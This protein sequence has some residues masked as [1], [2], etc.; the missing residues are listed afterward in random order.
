MSPTIAYLPSLLLRY[1]VRHT[2]SSPPLAG[3][4]TMV[5]V[6]RVTRVLLLRR[7]LQRRHPYIPSLSPPCPAPSWPDL[8]FSRS[9]PFSLA[10][11][12]APHFRALAREGSL[13]LFFISFLSLFSLFPSLP[14]S[15]PSCLSVAL[16][17]FS[18]Y[19]WE[20]EHASKLVCSWQTSSSF[21]ILGITLNPKP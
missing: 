18:T 3:L 6:L 12:P 14:P 5:H 21:M 4:N 11:A 16:A 19:Q 13:S 15:L 7:T 20:S 2:A 8:P 17:L 1:E 9:H 10:R